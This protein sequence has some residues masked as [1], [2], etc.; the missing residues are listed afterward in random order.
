MKIGTWKGED[1]STFVGLCYVRYA[2][3]LCYVSNAHF[4]SNTKFEKA[5]LTFWNGFWKITHNLY[6]SNNIKIQDNKLT[7]FL[8]WTFF[9]P[10]W[11]AYWNLFTKA[12]SGAG[13]KELFQIT[14]DMCYSY[15]SKLT[16]SGA[17]WESKR[18]YPFSI[19]I[20]NILCRPE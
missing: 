18:K 4:S 14:L 20:I 9:S 12:V 10:L 6:I 19:Y 11:K 16:V 15:N 5:D 7:C 2:M 3:Y 1:K 8:K 13:G 17:W